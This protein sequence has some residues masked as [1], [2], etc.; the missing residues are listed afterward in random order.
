MRSLIVLGIVVALGGC[1]TSGPIM[2]T[3]KAGTT[4]QQRQ[5]DH[6]ECKIAAFQQ[7]PQDLVTDYS[8]G[9]SSPGTVHCNTYGGVTT[10][11]TVGGV[12]IPPSV[13]T[14]DQNRDLR[15]RQ[16]Q[17]C[18]SERGYQLLPVVLCAEDQVSTYVSSPQSEVGAFQCVRSDQIHTMN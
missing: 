9:Y 13:N 10:C 4:L 5:L 18:M 14:Y 16:M 17:R 12:N 2:L 11:N 8:P 7:V 6:D 3:H 15:D 1:A